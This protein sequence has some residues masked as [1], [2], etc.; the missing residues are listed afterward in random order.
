MARELITT[1]NDYQSALDRLLAIACHAL[2]IYDE[3]LAH[4]KLESPDRLGE[5]K[6]ILK[7]GQPDTLQIAVRN[8]TRLRQDSPLLL[9]LLETFSHCSSARETPDSVS[10][11]RDSMIIADGKHALIRF[12]KDLPRSKLLIDEPEELRPYINRFSEIWDEGGEGVS[13]NTLGL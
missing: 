2:Y 12:E 8:A 5:L 3:D 11:L 10:H 6:R 13:S 1:W 4:L 9:G 7:H